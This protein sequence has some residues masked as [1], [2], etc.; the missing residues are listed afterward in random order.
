[1][2]VLLLLGRL[3]GYDGWLPVWLGVDCCGV[4]DQG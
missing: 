3:E 2:L 4:D 1:M